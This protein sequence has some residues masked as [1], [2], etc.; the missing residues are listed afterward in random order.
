MITQD[1]V[2][3]N[4]AAAVASGD[5]AALLTEA[6]RTSES[7]ARK[8]ALKAY[9]RVVAAKDA[10]IKAGNFAANKK[11]RREM[12]WQKIQRLELEIVTLEGELTAWGARISV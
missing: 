12:A 11:M 5:S 3:K 2:E 4:I 10:Q 1:Q 9:E 7:K 6:A 8:A